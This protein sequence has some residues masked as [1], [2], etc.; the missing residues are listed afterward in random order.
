MD[1]P[2]LNVYSFRLEYSPFKLVL[3]LINFLYCRPFPF[4]PDSGVPQAVIFHDS[5]SHGMKTQF[6]KEFRFSLYSYV[7]LLF[8]SLSATLF[9]LLHLELFE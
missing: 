5:W 8:G 9:C 4:H 1:E 7:C 6:I 3:S 2:L